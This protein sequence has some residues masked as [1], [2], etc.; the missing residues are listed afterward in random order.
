MIDEKSSEET[1][2]GYLFAM[3]NYS[4]FEGR[5]EVY[6]KNPCPHKVSGYGR[7]TFADNKPYY[8]W[9]AGVSNA[10]Y[11]LEEWGIIPYED[12]MQDDGWGEDENEDEDE[13]YI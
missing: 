6:T 3:D 7:S 1:K 11:D 9:N 12:E 13:E 5:A 8:D 2:A 10:Y 4:K